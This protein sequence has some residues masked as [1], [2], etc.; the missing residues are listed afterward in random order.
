[1]TLGLVGARAR[2]FHRRFQSGDPRSPWYRNL[3]ER[4]VAGTPMPLPFGPDAVRARS[5][6]QLIIKAQPAPGPG[7]RE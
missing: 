3:Y 1:M 6:Q 4:W 7:E 5:V 2:A